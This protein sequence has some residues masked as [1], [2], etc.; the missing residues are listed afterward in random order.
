[1][2]RSEQIAMDRDCFRSCY[3]RFRYCTEGGGFLRG[4]RSVEF[5]CD[6][7]LACKRAL[8]PADW[9]TFNAHYLLGADWNL[10]ARQL[11][12]PCQTHNDKK[13]FFE[14]CY[15]MEAKLGRVFRELQPFALWQCAD[16]FVE[17]ARGAKIVPTPLKEPARYQPLRPPL[18]KRQPRAPAAVAVMPAP[19]PCEPLPA[20][21]CLQ[22]A[23]RVRPTIAERRALIRA[24]LAA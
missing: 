2:N 13:N 23:K 10:C 4:Y 16:Y 21:A 14:A 15:R 5:M 9:R 17:K 1:M 18:A 7:Y 3:K 6:F 12:I 19:A 8:D 20:P 24:K 22:P 11:G